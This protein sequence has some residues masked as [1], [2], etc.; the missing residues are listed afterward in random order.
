MLPWRGYFSTLEG[1]AQLRFGWVRPKVDDLEFFEFRKKWNLKIASSFGLDFVV[2]GA[3]PA[4]GTLV[5]SN[6]SGFLD[7]N[8]LVATMPAASMP[9]FVSKKE[10][11]ELPIFGRHMGIYG[12][13]LFDRKDPDARRKALD[14]SL[15]RLRRGFTLVLF[16]EGT[17]QR[18]GVPT[19]K[20]RPALIEAALKE[21]IGVQPVAIKGTTNLMEK[22]WLGRRRNRVDI[23]YGPV[24]NDWRSAEEVWAEVLRMFAGFQR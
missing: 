17:R 5:V 7:I 21:G 18:S 1:A 6:H 4:A 16:P 19:Q 24:R 3:P 15:L 8:T 10:I 23:G 20:I 12:D 13:V 11:G 9:N 22:P 2:H 14:E